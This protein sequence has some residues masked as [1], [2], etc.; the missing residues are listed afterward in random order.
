MLRSFTTIFTYA[1][2]IISLVKLPVALM[3]SVSPARGGLGSRSTRSMFRMCPSATGSSQNFSGLEP[4]TE[5]SSSS[6]IVGS[7]VEK[8]EARVDGMRRRVR[9]RSFMITEL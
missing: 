4:G 8:R 3:V 6:R 7:E 2:S 5:R 9:G 1:P